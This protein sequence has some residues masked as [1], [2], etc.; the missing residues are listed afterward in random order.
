MLFRSTLPT[1]SLSSTPP[2][3]AHSNPTTTH[4]SLGVPSNRLPPSYK[5]A[6]KNSSSTKSLT[7]DAVPNKRNT[8]SDGKAKAPKATNGFQQ[9]KSKTAKPLTSGS[10]A[11]PQDRQKHLKSHA[12]PQIHQNIENPLDVVLRDYVLPYDNLLTPV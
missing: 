5:T 3:F 11:K 1:H 2:K 10:H 8:A 6:N 7:S 9:V 12:R 4:S